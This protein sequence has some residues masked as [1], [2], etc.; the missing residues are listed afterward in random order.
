MIS[1]DEP[2][3]FGSPRGL[4]RP[5]ISDM[6]EQDK[7]TSIIKVTPECRA[8]LKHVMRKDQRYSDFFIELLEYKKEKRT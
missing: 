7:V 2:E 5:I 8:L 3:L 4:F 1:N 6:K